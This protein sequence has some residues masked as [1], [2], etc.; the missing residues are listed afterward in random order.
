MRH[1]FAINEGISATVGKDALLGMVS[2]SQTVHVCVC[3]G[4]SSNQP[5]SLFPCSAV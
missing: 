4:G 2:L 3:V 1:S 5:Y